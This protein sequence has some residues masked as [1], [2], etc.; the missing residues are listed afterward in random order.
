MRGIADYYEHNYKTVYNDD[1]SQRYVFE[2]LFV[3]FPIDGKSGSFRLMS[4]NRWG[5]FISLT[6][7]A[8]RAGAA[9]IPAWTKPPHSYMIL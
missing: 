9:E 4:L 7:A 5:M 8:A 1:T 3:M 2:N 6:A